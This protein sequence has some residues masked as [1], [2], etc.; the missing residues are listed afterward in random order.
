MATGNIGVYSWDIELLRLV[1]TQLSTG[2]DDP[3]KHGDPTICFL[4]QYEVQNKAWDSY[5]QNE[6]FS[7][8]V[9]HY[10]IGPKEL[11]T[12]KP[13]HQLDDEAIW[14]YWLLCKEA[15][16]KDI[17][18]IDL[19]WYTVMNSEGQK[20][21]EKQAIKIVSKIIQHRSSIITPLQLSAGENCQMAYDA[22]KQ[23]KSI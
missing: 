13:K 12:L 4:Y 3:L 22:M 23:Y 19:W 9:Y 18:I 8:G 14:A 15:A 5:L 6:N 10:T 2:T 16:A 1:R 7:Q 17:I 20:N 11:S 21:R